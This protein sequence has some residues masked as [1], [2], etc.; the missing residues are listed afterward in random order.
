MKHMLSCSCKL[1]ATAGR[2]YGGSAAEQ[3]SSDWSQPWAQGRQ[4]GRQA[5]LRFDGRRK[6]GPN[7]TA[8]RKR[9]RL[10]RG[11]LGGG[12]WHPL[13]RRRRAVCEDVRRRKKARKPDKA[14]E[15]Q[16]EDCRWR[17]REKTKDALFS[18]RRRADGFYPT[19]QRTVA[20]L[21]FL[22]HHS[23]PCIIS[24]F[25]FTCQVR[26]REHWAWLAPQ[27]KLGDE[28]ES[29]GWT[30]GWSPELSFSRITHKKSRIFAWHG[31]TQPVRFGI[32]PLIRVDASWLWNCKL[33][34]RASRRF[35]FTA[36]CSWRH[37]S[38]GIQFMLSPPLSVHAKTEIYMIL[39]LSG[40][41]FLSLHLQFLYNCICQSFGWHVKCDCGSALRF[42][43]FV[44][45][46]HFSQGS[47]SK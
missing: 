7:G 14:S 15:N 8:A 26:T 16:Y 20:C 32:Y 35:F 37:S 28:E 12:E 44:F 2:C 31:T 6:A 13:K 4:A 22:K 11:R 34:K 18:R 29:L 41:F 27:K 30:S 39:I 36:L 47:R 25:P 23:A 46:G 38:L 3:A 42:F 43:F 17:T 10:H 5:V 45:G 9:L 33:K 19:S 40:K 1:S 21:Y 24:N